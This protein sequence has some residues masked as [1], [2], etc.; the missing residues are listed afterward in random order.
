MMPAS[1][2]AASVRAKLLANRRLGTAGAA[3]LARAD[4]LGAALELLTRSAYGPN[5]EPG[6]SVEVAQRQVA[7]T[8]LWHVR[9]MAGWLPPGG[10]YVLQPL[11][12]WFEIANI[13]ERL[14]YLSGGD[15]PP[16]YQL[17]RM[18]TAWRAV[19]AVTTPDAIRDA[20]TRSRWGDPG[21]SDPGGMV[22]ALRF[23][24]AAWISGAVP[25]AAV[26]AESAAALLAARLCFTLPRGS[27]APFGGLVYGLP[28]GWELAGSA[29]ELAAM[30]PHRLAWVLDGVLEPSDLWMAESRWWARVR[31]DAIDMFLRSQF[32]SSVVVGV[33]ALLAHDAWL[34]RAALSAAA[35]GGAARGVFD[36]VA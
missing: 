29:P 33:A 14:A 21:T 17:G 8:A 13:E 11:A 26:W 3:G 36:A 6:M 35:R 18:G 16:P 2:V 20:L 15:H 19:A 10:S 24:W 32:D 25:G 31:R 30:L 5:L 23:R 9:L 27:L 12:A 1:W 28:A 4:G 7:A 34:V 22:L